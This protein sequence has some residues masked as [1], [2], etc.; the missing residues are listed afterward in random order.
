MIQM[1]YD[2]YLYLSISG[3][4]AG[5][6]P[7]VMFRSAKRGRRPLRVR[8][9]RRLVSPIAAFMSVAILGAVLFTSWRELFTAPGTSILMFFVPLALLWALLRLPGFA[10]FPLFIIV[11][12]VLSFGAVR[13]FPGGAASSST[14]VPG[15]PWIAVDRLGTG[16]E[17]ARLRALQDGET[18]ALDLRPS[19]PS[20]VRDNPDAEY[21]VSLDQTVTLDVAYVVRPPALWFL[22]PRVILVEMRL[23]D[24]QSLVLRRR[25]TLPTVE[26]R[27]EQIFD[28]TLFVRI[29]DSVRHPEDGTYL[30]A[31]DHPV[32]LN[33]SGAET[34]THNNDGDVVS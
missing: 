9:L 20:L 19:A 6:V 15:I 29:E 14:S 3:A 7:Y 27:V 24:S 32:R 18:L 30:Q 31:G 23:R 16:E 13:T 4:V 34:D 2:P 33:D 12:A 22:G 26:E 1:R 25:R 5:V 11:A 28:G 8:A 10:A 17:I 21:I